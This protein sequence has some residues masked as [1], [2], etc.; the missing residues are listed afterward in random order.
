VKA[1]V[2]VD[3]VAPV[4]IVLK[5]LEPA[6]DGASAFRRAQEGAR[7]PAR[8][9]RGRVPQRGLTPG[10]GGQLDGELVAVEV[11][12]FLERFDEQKIDGKPHGPAPVGVSSED[13]R[14]R[15]GRLIIDAMLCPV[16]M[17]DVGIVFVELETERMPCGERN[18][19]SSRG[20]GARTPGGAGHQR[21]QAT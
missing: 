18:S 21:E 8:D 3:E 7:E 17:Q 9:F 10:A 12:K 4:W 14:A 20:T 15:V 11:M 6:V 2:K 1:F 16:Y 13:P 5:L 19:D